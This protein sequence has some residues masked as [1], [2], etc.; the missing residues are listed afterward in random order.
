LSIL[1][2]QIESNIVHYSKLIFVW[3]LV[4]Y[5]KDCQKRLSKKSLEQRSNALNF[6]LGKSGQPDIA[7]ES[8][9][10]IITA[11]GEFLSPEDVRDVNMMSQP[12]HIPY[13]IVAES[14][15]QQHLK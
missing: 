12:R 13:F 11:K 15:C 8:V 1:F 6:L 5:S 7:A 4:V 10:M 2:K 3:I 9:K 14:L